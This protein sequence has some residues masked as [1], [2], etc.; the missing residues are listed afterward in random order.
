M[1][2]NALLF[3]HF[4]T[5]HPLFIHFMFLC[6]KQLSWMEVGHFFI[7][8]IIC[9]HMHP[10]TSDTLCYGDDA[11]ASQWWPLHVTSSFICSKPWDQTQFSKLLFIER[12]KL[13]NMQTQNVRLT[14]LP[15]IDF[16]PLPVYFVGVLN[17][18]CQILIDVVQ[19]S[20][21]HNKAIRLSFC[22]FY[23]NAMWKPQMHC[24]RRIARQWLRTTQ[25]TPG[26][27]G[28]GGI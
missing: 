17:D 21:K 4:S 8:E 20:D 27:G 24:F 1:C 28:G 12:G 15:S 10:V 3:I 14:Y 5:I 23:F 25:Q 13:D 7:S 22:V 2:L 19:L 6:L 16:I 9:V 26:W 11:N 18:Y